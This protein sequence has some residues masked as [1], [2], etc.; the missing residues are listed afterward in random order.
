MD[1][2]RRQV[3]IPKQSK[4]GCLGCFAGFAILAGYSMMT[5]VMIAI[6]LAALAAAVWIIVKVLQWMG[7][8]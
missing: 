1:T 7:V 2:F 8:L 6:N 3:R 4:S 5:V